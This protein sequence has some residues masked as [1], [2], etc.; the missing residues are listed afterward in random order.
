VNESDKMAMKRE[1]YESWRRKSDK[2]LVDEMTGGLR[3]TVLREACK[4]VALLVYASEDSAHAA[5]L[6]P[7]V[8]VALVFGYIIFAGQRLLLCPQP[9][10]GR[11]NEYSKLSGS[12]QVAY[13]AAW[14]DMYMRK[15]SVE[16]IMSE[17]HN[18]TYESRRFGFWK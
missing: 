5:V 10:M 6:L 14:A 9:E 15:R 4:V 8:L 18:N 12:D 1:I 11:G 13:A 3:A 2:Q 16:E 17:C 7:L